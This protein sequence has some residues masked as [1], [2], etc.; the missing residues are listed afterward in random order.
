MGIFL[1]GQLVKQ[2]LFFW[3]G[4]MMVGGLAGCATR[5]AIAPKP[6]KIGDVMGDWYVIAHV[7]HWSERNCFASLLRLRQLPNQRIDVRY[8]AQKKSIYGRKYLVK[9]MADVREPKVGT[10]WDFQFVSGLYGFRATFLAVADDGR[11]AVLMTPDRRRAWI[12]SRKRS[13]S[14]ADFEAALRV[15]D[16]Q[17]FTI[18][19][20]VAVPQIPWA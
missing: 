12:L 7:P 11:Y 17:G 19:R 2:K 4:V 15:L 16:E 8:I 14:G 10:S 1:Q 18:R 5:P 3:I 20:L 13:L 6:V 9:G